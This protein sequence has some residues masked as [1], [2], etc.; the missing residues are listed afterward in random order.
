MTIHVDLKKDRHKINSLTIR[1]LSPIFCENDDHD[2]L[3]VCE[4]KKN[5]NENPKKNIKGI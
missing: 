2:D 1:A 4:W 5:K 3:F